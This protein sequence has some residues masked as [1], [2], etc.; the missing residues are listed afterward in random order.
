MKCKQCG[1]THTP[2]HPHFKLAKD[3]TDK[4]FPVHTKGYAAAHEEADKEEKK[5]FGKKTYEALKKV[6]NKLKKHELEGKN[7]KSGELEVS[8]KVP[9]KLRK[10]VAFHEE[11]ESKILKKKR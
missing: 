5:A 6:G 11:V 8:V 4:H 3:L 2:V 7:L 9:K 1:L 10:E